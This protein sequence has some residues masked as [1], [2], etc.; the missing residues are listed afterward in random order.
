MFSVLTCATKIRKSEEKTDIKENFVA[1]P[2]FNQGG[3]K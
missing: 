1:I 3:H 2:Q